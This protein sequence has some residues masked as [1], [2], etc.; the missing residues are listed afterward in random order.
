MG[1]GLITGTGTAETRASFEP[2]ATLSVSGTKEA[3]VGP[4]GRWAYLAVTDGYATVDLARPTDP[5]LA[6]E[7]RDL[8]ADTEAGRMRK[9]FDVKL[10]GETLAVVGPANP[11]RETTTSGLL[12]VDVS[13]PTD[14]E[15]LGFFETDYSI[16]NCAFADSVVYLTGNGA[17]EEANP[18]VVVDASDPT[19]P[20]EVARWRLADHDERW[21]GVSQP[22]HD[23]WV[24]DELAAL[25]HWD[26][27]TFLLDVSDPTDP[28]HLGTVSALSPDELRDGSRRQG[29]LPPG[30]HHYTA[31]DPANELLAIGKE[32]W[33]LDAD[34]GYRGGPSGIELVDVSDPTDPE[35]RAEIDPPPT[36]NPTFS[37][38]WT[39][40][41]NLALRDDTLYSSW[42]DGGVK[43]FDV[44]D[45]ANPEQRSWWVDPE[46][47]RFWTA[48]VVTSDVFLASTFG[49]DAGIRVFP[50]AD[51]TG[52]DPE[53]LTETDSGAGGTPQDTP[54]GTG[55]T[56]TPTDTATA[57]PT[58][59]PA[60]PAQSANE[61]TATTPGFGAAA[62]VGGVGTL[63][64]WLRERGENSD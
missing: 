40:A 14:P 53:A 17:E 56:A 33:G 45:P 27:G 44:S 51:G 37:G 23:V 49:R 32:S 21:A 19:Q 18:L 42:Y 38:V 60:S 64:W 52:G 10:D 4:D 39:T 5:R 6:A 7:R 61:T 12:L 55:E 26:A 48:Q 30:N 31:T 34:D 2:S 8:F 35:R 43:R 11:V 16:H 22:L 58:G 1:L 20:T 59:T 28:T 57:T 9:V 62:A 46:N 3:V 50:N 41:H 36:P 25:A 54:G 29:V 24:R 13:D 63:A 15:R 47:T